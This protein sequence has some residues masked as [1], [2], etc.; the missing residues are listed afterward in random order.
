MRQLD[1]AS[2]AI[3]I[4]SGKTV[5]S[6][7]PTTVSALEPMHS[8]PSDAE[9][10]LHNYV[11]SISIIFSSSTKC[12][13]DAAEQNSNLINQMPHFLPFNPPSPPIL[14]DRFENFM[15]NCCTVGAIF[16]IIKILWH[17]EE[18]NLFIWKWGRFE[19]KYYL[20]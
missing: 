18:R 16:N 6:L 8:V 12:N 11:V 13:R 9:K 5:N 17:F 14:T 4:L 2:K 20:V 7:R 1:A 15:I 10:F 19:E 3:F